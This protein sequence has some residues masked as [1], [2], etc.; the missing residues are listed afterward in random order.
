MKYY[1]NL[2]NE[3][4]TNNFI[5]EEP[6]EIKTNLNFFNVKFALEELTN[7]EISECVLI[8]EKENEGKYIFNNKATSTINEFVEFKNIE[9]KNPIEYEAR[10][11]IYFELKQGGITILSTKK[12]AIYFILHTRAS[13][14]EIDFKDA[15]YLDGVHELQKE[16]LNSISFNLKIDSLNNFEYFFE[17]SPEDE[18]AP[19]TYLL[20]ESNNINFERELTVDSFKN[21]FTFLHF[22]LKDS[23]NNIKYKKYKITTKNN[24][25]TLMYLL[26]KE[27]VLPKID[28]EFSIFY[29][30]RNV[31][32]IKPVIQYVINGIS[33]QKEGKE[34]GTFNQTSKYVLLNLKEQFEKIEAKEVV[35]FFVLNQSEKLTSNSVLVLLDDE[36]PEIEFQE[37]HLINQK[38]KENLVINGKIVDKNLFF[39]GNS[40][41]TINPKKNILFINSNEQ[42]KEISLTNGN[43]VSLEKFSDYY[44]CEYPEETFEVFNNQNNKI[45]NVTYLTA[46][47]QNKHFYIWIDYNKLT[48]FEKNIIETQGQLKLKGDILNYIHTQT[49]YKFENIYL[50]KITLTGTLPEVLSFDFGIDGF[51]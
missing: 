36:K 10:Y 45:D 50:I 31:T 29:E 39:I 3:N 34:I 9:F 20:L 22:Y 15:V 35:L 4:K 21:G 51:E 7:L 47:D 5:F 37:Y 25:F 46:N 43:K 30:S 16:N 26:N 27:I 2:F 23:F 33:Y 11:R 24:T 28:T 32:T 1:F 38:E 18:V 41:K 17:L 12:D 13:D 44:T 42:L 19:K 40:I 48:I 14:F 49:V 8:V 6:K